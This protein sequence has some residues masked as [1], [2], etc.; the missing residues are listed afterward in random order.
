MFEYLHPNQE[1]ENERQNDSAIH[2]QMNSKQY[3]STVF[4]STTNEAYARMSSLEVMMET[5]NHRLAECFN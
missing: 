5:S 2:L 4:F 3:Q 1:K